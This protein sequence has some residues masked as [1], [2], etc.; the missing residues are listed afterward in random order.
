[1]K[2]NRKY[3]NKFM[4]G[5]FRVNYPILYRRWVLDGERRWKIIDSKKGSA[6]LVKISFLVILIRDIVMIAWQIDKKK[7][8]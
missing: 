5:Y 6:K 1:M 2:A 4:E 8:N 3:R 7:R